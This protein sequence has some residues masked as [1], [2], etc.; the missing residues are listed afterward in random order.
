MLP[1]RSHV[2][3][4]T[5]LWSYVEASIFQ[6][7]IFCSFLSC[8]GFTTR[9]HFWF[10]QCVRVRGYP[11]EHVLQSLSKTLFFQGKGLQLEVVVHLQ[12]RQRS[13]YSPFPSLVISVMF[14]E[15]PVVSCKSVMKESP[16]SLEI[17]LYTPAFS[18]SETLNFI[19]AGFNTRDLCSSPWCS[20]NCPARSLCSR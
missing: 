7:G 8:D 14:L 5:R 3:P 20:S 1:Q 11:T 15:L 4:L 19:L 10:Q 17:T 9:L 13:S 18:P 2:W 12:E 16:L 6:P